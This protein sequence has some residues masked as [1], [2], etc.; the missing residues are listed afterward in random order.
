MKRFFGGLVKQSFWHK[1]GFQ[2][3]KTLHRVKNLS[4][5][6]HLMKSTLPWRNIRVS[7]LQEY[8]QL[9]GEQLDD[10]LVSGDFHLQ[11]YPWLRDVGDELLNY[12]IEVR[13]AI[14]T[15]LKTAFSWNMNSWK[16][17][18]S[19]RVDPKMRR[20]KKL[21]KDGPVL[22]QETKWHNNQEEILLQHISGL[23]IVN[24][25]LSGGAAVLLPAGWTI[26][27][28]ISLLAGRAVAVLIN[29]RCASFYL[30][31]VYLRPDSV[32][33]ELEQIIHAWR[34]TEKKSDKIVI[35]GDFNQA[36]TKC[37]ELWK[38]FLSL[39]SV[40]DVHPTF[41]TYLFSGGTSALDRCLVP[42][43]WVS[44][45]KWNPEVRALNSSLVNGHKILKLSVKVRPTVL[46][47]PNDCLHETI[48]TE[49]FMPGKNGRLP[50]DN[51]ALQSLVRHSQDMFCKCNPH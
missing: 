30:V 17:P 5:L 16:T 19:C 51:R 31:S 42:E 8:L 29:D 18:K 3:P 10:C 33:R 39:F 22:L 34:N 28:K 13:Q 47:N 38:K 7:D 36:D 35:G 14:P 20:I 26:E 49:A 48:T 23:Q 6:P 24:A 46:N 32:H 50:K 25:T 1:F 40:V 44:T 11:D 21:L 43:D 27:Q 9:S 41:A 4:F 2:C 12:R 45:A 37:P 15:R